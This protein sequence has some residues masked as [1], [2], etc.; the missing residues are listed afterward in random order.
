VAPGA[1]RRLDELTVREAGGAAGW[2]AGV[3]GAELAGEGTRG[4]VGLEDVGVS[5]IKGGTVT[6]GVLAGLS[7]GLSQV[8]K[9][10]SSFL[11]SFAT[12]AAMPSIY[13][14]AV[15]NC[16]ASAAE[17]LANSSLYFKAAAQVYLSLTLPV[18]AEKEPGCLASQSLNDALPPTF[19]VRS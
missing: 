1:E 16:E 11:G 6:E 7:R 10:S 4:V 2:T 14:R 17:R 5:E 18:E 9:K 13:T 8:L 15:P 12:G 3:G 19:M